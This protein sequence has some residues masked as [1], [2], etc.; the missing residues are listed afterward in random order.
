MCQNAFDTGI[1]IGKISDP[2]RIIQGA[3]QCG[4]ETKARDLMVSLILG[5]GF[6]LEFRDDGWDV[7]RLNIQKS[8]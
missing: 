2:G 7:T 8:R 3:L 1:R 4:P 6:W 5:N